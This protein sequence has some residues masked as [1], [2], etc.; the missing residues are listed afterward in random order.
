MNHLFLWRTIPGRGEDASLLGFLDH[1]H[2]HAHT[3]THTYTLLWTS[4]QPVAEAAQHKTNTTDEYPCPQWDL[5]PRSQKSSACR[6]TPQT[7]RPK[8]SAKKPRVHMTLLFL[9]EVCETLSFPT[10][11]DHSPYPCTGQGIA[12]SIQ[13]KHKEKLMTQ[14]KKYFAKYQYGPRDSFQSYGKSRCVVFV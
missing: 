1:T 10:A 8:G 9:K 7:V 6:P 13:D 2:T 4:D 14:T 12:V 5:N 11:S 3:H